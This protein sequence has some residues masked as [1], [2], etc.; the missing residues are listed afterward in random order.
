MGFQRLFLLPTLT[1]TDLFNYSDAP[2]D[3]WLKRERE[4]I[5]K[6]SPIPVKV[7]WHYAHSKINL[8]K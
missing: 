5:C 8:F 4:R 2:L 7:S 1:Q 3:T 6:G